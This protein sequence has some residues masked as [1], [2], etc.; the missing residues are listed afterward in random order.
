MFA[1]MIPLRSERGRAKNW[2]L[3]THRRP[4]YIPNSQA[5][6]TW[7]KF[8][9]TSIVAVQRQLIQHRLPRDYDYHRIPAPWIQIKLLKVGAWL[10]VL[11]CAEF[12]QLVST[13]RD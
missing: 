4:L 11:H 7:G 5:D 8:L 10:K 2:I 12:S 6:P 1:V 3:H 9:V 13:R